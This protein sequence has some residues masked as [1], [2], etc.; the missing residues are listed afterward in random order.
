MGSVRVMFFVYLAVITA[1]LAFALV[2]GL[3]GR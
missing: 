3:Q 2:V 1:G